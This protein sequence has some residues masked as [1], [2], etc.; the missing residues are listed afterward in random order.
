MAVIN[1]GFNHEVLAVVEGGGN[2]ANHFKLA[3]ATFIVGDELE[4][5]T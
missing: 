4:S 2:F 1:F 5:V 3:F